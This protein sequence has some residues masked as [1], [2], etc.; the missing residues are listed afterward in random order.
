MKLLD[1]TEICI[2]RWSPPA[3]GAWIETC[4]GRWLKNVYRVAPR[5]GGVD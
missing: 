2:G 5:A 4:N 1:I 3:R